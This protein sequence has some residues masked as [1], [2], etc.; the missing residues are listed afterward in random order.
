MKTEKLDLNKEVIIQVK[1]TYSF[2]PADHLPDD[3]DGTRE[4]V[5][6]YFREDIAQNFDQWVSANEIYEHTQEV[7]EEQERLEEA[8][9]ELLAA[10][11]DAVEELK[12][13]PHIV[14]L[15]ED[16]I[17]RAKAAIAKAEGRAE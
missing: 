4:D 3:Y 5:V 12:H 15:D 6:S 9:P 7:S 11:R 1:L 10:L 16:A 8:A 2:V 13:A 14:N 17:G